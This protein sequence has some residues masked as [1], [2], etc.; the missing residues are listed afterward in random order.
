MVWKGVIIEESLE[1]K[2]ILN[3]VKIVNSEKMTLENE[4][5]RG[6][7]IFHQ[8]ELDDDKKDEFL[9]EALSSI[10]DKF[11]L[12]VCKNDFMIVVYR[13]KMFEFSSNESDKLKEARNY[14]LS[15]GILKEQMPFE[16]LIK[17]PHT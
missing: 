8:I 16:N 2:S 14:G 17:N 6:F 3:L 4:S 10:K 13:N 5:E 1:D 11:Y 9:E 7:L 12:H 15:L